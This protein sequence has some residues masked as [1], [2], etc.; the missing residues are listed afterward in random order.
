MNPAMVLS[1]VTTLNLKETNMAEEIYLQ[2]LTEKEFTIAFNMGLQAAVFVLEKAENI[3][4]E[5]RSYL[6]DELKKQIE[7]SEAG[8]MI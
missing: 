7:N 4:P 6:L 1:Q 5:G 3:S 2:S 8:H